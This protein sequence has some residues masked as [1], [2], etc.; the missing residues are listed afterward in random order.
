[1]SAM[2]KKLIEKTIKDPY[3]GTGGSKGG[4]N[5][6]TMKPISKGKKKKTQ[7]LPSNYNDSHHV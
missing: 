1:M 7:K 5:V 2:E 6:D 3:W 4:F